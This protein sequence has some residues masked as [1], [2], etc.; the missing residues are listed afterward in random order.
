MFEKNH[1]NLSNITELITHNCGSCLAIPA[2]SS[3]LLPSAPNE[4]ISKKRTHQKKKSWADDCGPP[5][6][7]ATPRSALPAA[8]AP[9]IF[10]DLLIPAPAQAATKKKP[11]RK[12]NGFVSAPVLTATP[13]YAQSAASVAVAPPAPTPATGNKRIRPTKKAIANP[14]NPDL[15]TEQ[16][17]TANKERHSTAASKVVSFWKNHQAE[18]EVLIPKKAGRGRGKKAR[19]A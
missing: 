12:K 3:G 19:G 9:A 7:K 1:I 8:S 16:P 10:S 18:A 5:D 2:V 11:C 4:V 6:L 13:A 17:S 14:G 15:E